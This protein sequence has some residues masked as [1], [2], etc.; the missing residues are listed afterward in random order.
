VP[1]SITHVTIHVKNVKNV[2]ENVVPHDAIVVA[3]DDTVDTKFVTHHA[4]LV[5]NGKT[6][7]INEIFV[8]PPAHP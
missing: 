2:V 8:T 4:I 7:S 3:N 5:T 1:V 6:I